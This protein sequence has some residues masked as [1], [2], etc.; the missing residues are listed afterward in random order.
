[1]LVLGVLALA[2]EVLVLLVFTPLLVES[3]IMIQFLLY[4]KIVA[5]A[6]E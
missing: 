1:M 3:F 5:F 6:K 4:I 2:L